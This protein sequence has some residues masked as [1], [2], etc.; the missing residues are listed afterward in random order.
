MAFL[1]ANNFFKIWQRNGKLTVMVTCRGCFL[2][3]YSKDDS[4]KRIIYLYFL[5]RLFWL[6]EKKDIQSK[7][8]ILSY[9]MHGLSTINCLQPLQESALEAVYGR[10]RASLNIWKKRPWKIEIK[11]Q[12]LKGLWIGL[13]KPSENIYI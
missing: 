9:S 11:P 4:S 6:Y 7:L 8:N 2:H 12:K 3:K 10:H 1:E 13:R 5:E